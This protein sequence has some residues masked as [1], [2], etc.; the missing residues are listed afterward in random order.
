[1]KLLKDKIKKLGQIKDGDVL[2]VDEFLNH[3]IDTKLVDKMADEFIKRFKGIKF[4]KVLTIETSGIAVAYPV[5]QKLGVPLVFAKKRDSVNING[6]KYSSKVIS[7]THFREYDETVS[8]KFLS[9]KDHILIIDDFLA[10]GSPLRGLL[11]IC[12]Q[13][14]AKVDGIG[15]AIEKVYQNGG[16]E[17]RDEGYRVE[18]LVKILEI[19]EKTNKIKFGD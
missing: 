4:T 10:K 12:I 13:A 5:A 7:Y 15:I 2:K 17:L 18:S 8:K 14:G 19:D 3:Q 6:E 1:M 16:N 9:N 11:S